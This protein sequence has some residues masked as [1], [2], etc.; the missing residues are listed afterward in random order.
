M[1]LFTLSPR[2]AEC[3]GLVRVGARLADVGADHAKLPVW[4]ARQGLIE[5]AVACDVSPGS[6]ASA[7]RN[8]TLHRAG[9][10][11]KTRLS[12]GLTGIDPDEADDI[13]IAGMGGEL[14]AEILSGASWIKNPRYNLILQPM[15]RP[16]RLRRWLLES[17]FEI[18]SEKAV[19]DA[20]R[21]YVV[22][23]ARFCSPVN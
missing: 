3:A 16:E 21:L 4:L 9:H 8:I 11:V 18:I 12:D 22:I 6:L 19:P 14:I 7:N 5:S 13:V 17:G 10:M 20:G 23:Q 2:L 15:S 1:R